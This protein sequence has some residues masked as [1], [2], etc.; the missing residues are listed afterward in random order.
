MENGLFEL[1]KETFVSEETKRVQ[2]HYTG[3][4]IN[5]WLDILSTKM[6]DGVLVTIVDFTHMKKLQI[7]LE[8]IV[9]ELRKSNSYLEEFAYAASHDLKD[10][11]TQ[12]PHICRPAQAC[13]GKT[14]EHTGIRHV[15]QDAKCYQAN[16]ATGR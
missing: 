16:A 14:H 8:R 12:D 1:Y 5:A 2:K 9:S 15:R 4:T 13:P 3:E 7:D 10:T 6:E 11:H